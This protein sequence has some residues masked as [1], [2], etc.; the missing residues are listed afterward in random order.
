[1]LS[2]S[3]RVLLERGVQTVISR[4]ETE[5][6]FRSTSHLRVVV[7]GE[8]LVDL[9]LR[10]PVVANTFSVTKSVLGTLAGIAAR[11]G[12]LPDVD[13]ALL[14]VVP[15]AEFLVGA[16]A[17]QQ[18]LRSLLSM[19]RGAQ[20]DGPYDMDA[21]AALPS[22]QIQRIASAPQEMAP[23]VR[24]RYDNGAAHLLAHVL[25]RLLA[26]PLEAFAEREL[27]VPLGIQRWRW[28][29]DPDGVPYG[30]AH[31]AL[32]AE[33]LSRLGLLWLQGGSWGSDP[34]MDLD[35]LRCMT[36][37]WSAPIPPEQQRYGWLMWVDPYG[38]FAGGWA[39]QHLSVLP[40]AEAVIVTTG[41]PKFEFGPPPTD[42]LPPDWRPARELVLEHLVPVLIP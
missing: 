6:E 42:A 23:G 33:S 28:R 3:R 11:H 2:R 39:G 5:P 22:G 8:V 38:Y 29:K 15:S 27:F 17:A 9:H 30:D 26:E 20:V 21:V 36:T 10:G 14:E 19:T 1:M 25:T 41:D 16:P 4:L 7:A 34:I 13:A 40:S 18:T 32:S 35:F 37:P 31:L 12:R 24:C